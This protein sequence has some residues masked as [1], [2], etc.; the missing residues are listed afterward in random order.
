MAD[1]RQTGKKAI[2]RGVDLP[3]STKHSMN[4]LRFIKGR[5][6]DEAIEVLEKVIKYDAAVPFRGE[7]PHKKGIPA[8]YPINASKVFIKLLKSLAANASQKGLNEARIRIS[9]KADLASRSSRPGR[10]GRRKF[11][12]THV[13]LIAEEK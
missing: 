9:G 13:L 3:I 5:K 11:K 4:I 10:H 2:A 1:E 6:I 8:R 7:I 12:R